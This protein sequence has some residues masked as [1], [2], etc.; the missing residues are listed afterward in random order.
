[1]LILVDFTGFLRAFRKIQN[2]HLVFYKCL[3]KKER[4]QKMK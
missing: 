1:M 4:L 2:G 3:K